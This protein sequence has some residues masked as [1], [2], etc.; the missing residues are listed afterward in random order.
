MQSMCNM[1]NR[2]MSYWSK[3]KSQ[4]ENQI[5]KWIEQIVMDAVGED[6]MSMGINANVGAKRAVWAR[7]SEQFDLIRRQKAS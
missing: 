4:I 3:K 7:W 1:N 5:G 2:T 6:G